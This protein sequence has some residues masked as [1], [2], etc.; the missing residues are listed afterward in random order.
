V[1]VVVEL[2]FLELLGREALVA[3]V[4]VVFKVLPE[5]LEPLTQEVVEV[6][7]VALERQVAQA[8]QA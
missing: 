3:A 8:V 7:A 2:V 5:L 1:E 4:L 6:E